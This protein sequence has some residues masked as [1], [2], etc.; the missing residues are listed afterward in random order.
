ML[1]L[2]VAFPFICIFFIFTLPFSV[3]VMFKDW[4]WLIISV[5]ALFAIPQIIMTY[6][7]IEEEFEEGFSCGISES[8]LEQFRLLRFSVHRTFRQYIQSAL[9][10]IHG[11]TSFIQQ[12]METISRRFGEY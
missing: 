9:V 2:I 12:V 7:E 6:F 1:K 10:P 8:L 5:F 11:E 4:Y 3:Y